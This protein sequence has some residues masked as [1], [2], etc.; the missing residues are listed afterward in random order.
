MQD[1]PYVSIRSMIYTHSRVQLRISRETHYFLSYAGGPPVVQFS[2]WEWAIIR[3]ALHRT[4]L[5]KFADLV[6]APSS[7]EGAMRSS[8]QE[9]ASRR[10][11]QVLAAVLSLFVTTPPASVAE[12]LVVALLDDLLDDFQT[13]AKWT[14]ITG[15]AEELL[16]QISATHDG[17]VLP[18]GIA[19]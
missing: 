18:A 10:P 5:K 19:L 16:P 15:S 7:V 17:G 1:G 8:C 14:P 4:P 3:T 2:C 13:W 12:P 11:S 9:S 6:D